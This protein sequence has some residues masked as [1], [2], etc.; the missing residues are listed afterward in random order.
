MVSVIFSDT[1]RSSIYEGGGIRMHPDKIKMLNGGEVLEHG[2]GPDECLANDERASCVSVKGVVYVMNNDRSMEMLQRLHS[3]KIMVTDNGQVA[4]I[5]VTTRLQVRMRI[6]TD[7]SD[8][9]SHM[10]SFS[11]DSTSSCMS[12][13]VGT[14]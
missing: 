3:D 14:Y 8:E 4:E 1:L 13:S 9:G 10:K 11:K 6:Q 7:G 2:L 5:M 12:Q